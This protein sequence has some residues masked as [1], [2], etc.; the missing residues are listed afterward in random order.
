[1]PLYEFKCGD[2][3]AE[4]E[5]L[6]NSGEEQTDLSCLN[7]GSAKLTKLMSS[8]AIKGG[9]SKSAKQNRCAICEEADG[10]TRVVPAVHINID[11][12]NG[13]SSVG[14]GLLEIREVSSPTPKDRRKL[15]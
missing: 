1:M 15:H 9:S 3:G 2:C 12:E 6:V 10:S 13:S 4:Q 7:C 8:F 14:M 5:C 11:P